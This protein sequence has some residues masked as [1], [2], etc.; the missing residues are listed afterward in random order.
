LFSFSIGANGAVTSVN[1]APYYSNYSVYPPLFLSA[2][3][4]L[5]FN[6]AGTYFRAD[7]LTYVGTLNVNS[8]T[9]FSHSASADE[10]IATLAPKSYDYSGNGPS[11]LILTYESSYRRFTGSLF[12]ADASIA[13]PVIGGSQSYGVAVYHGANDN[14]VALVQTGGAASNAANLKY[15]VVVTR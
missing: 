14:H 15:Y 6:S 3:E 5:V 13:L 1:Q 11:V 10:A 12:F 4:D 7:T 2:S 8:I 9:S